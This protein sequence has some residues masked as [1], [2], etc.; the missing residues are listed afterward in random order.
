MAFLHCHEC[1]WE[2]DDFW[3][4]HYNPIKSLERIKEDF[5]TKDLDAPW[6]LECYEIPSPLPLR[7]HLAERLEVWARTVRNMKWPTMESWLDAD[8]PGCPQCGAPLDMD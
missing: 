3:D 2:Q 5:Y 7:E 1:D 4:E 6:T 8:R